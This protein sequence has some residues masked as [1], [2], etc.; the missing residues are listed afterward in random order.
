MVPSFA[1][2]SGGAIRSLTRDIQSKN[3]DDQRR[4]EM[5]TLIMRGRFYPALD[6]ETEMNT[7]FSRH[8]VLAVFCWSA[9]YPLGA[10]AR[11][12]ERLSPFKQLCV[13][14]MSTGFNWKNGN[15]VPVR[16]KEKRYIVSKIDPPKSLNL[17]SERGEIMAFVECTLPQKD[18]EELILDNFHHFPACLK[19]Q[20][21]GEDRPNFLDC[22][23]THI[24][25]EEEKWSTKISC[26]NE[27]AFSPNGHFHS[28]IFHD[29]VDSKPKNDYKDSLSISVG[30]CGSIEN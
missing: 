20:I 28:S 5:L 23:E 27:F 29:N 7:M 12:G 10:H 6:P 13:A 25:D 2:W 17:A 24:K 30:K 19:I 11:D 9:I 3:V 18:T 1:A 15:W 21:L 22:W 8:V 26:G 14:D 4:A 16:F